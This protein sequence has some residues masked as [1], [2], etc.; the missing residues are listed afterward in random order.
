HR[1]QLSIVD[2]IAINDVQFYRR[3]TGMI[4]GERAGALVL[5]R[6]VVAGNE[7]ARRSNG[8]KQI[9]R[10]GPAVGRNLSAIDQLVAVANHDDGS[11]SIS[12]RRD[13]TSVSDESVGRR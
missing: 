13:G 9:A 10:G 1:R 3:R 5:D 12:L 7:H 6:D 4:A 8:A 11:G 2:T